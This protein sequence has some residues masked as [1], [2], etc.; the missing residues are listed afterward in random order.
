MNKAQHSENKPP[1]VSVL[2]LAYNH[3][4]YIEECLESIASQVCNFP[5]EV[6]VGEDCSPDDTR[7]KVVQIAARY[8]GLIRPILSESNLGAMMNSRNLTELARGKYIAF[9]EGDDYW[10]VN[11]KLQRQVDILE[12]DPE[13]TLVCA[14]ADA[15]FH[16]TGRRIRSIHERNGQ[17]DPPPED[18]TE[19]LLTRRINLFTCTACSPRE[20][21]LKAYRENPYEFS[22]NHPM[23]AI[24]LFL[25]L[26]R[27][28]KVVPIRESMATY[29]V[30]TESTSRS[31][32]LSKV[33][34]FQVAA[35]EICEHY[36]RKFGYGPDVFRKIWFSQFWTMFDLVMRS[37]NQTLREELNHLIEARAIHPERLSQ[38]LAFWILDKP[39]R[40]EQYQR[41]SSYFL[42]ARRAK[43]RL[44]SIA[45]RYA[46]EAKK[47]LARN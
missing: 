47:K 4:P 10:N 16:N 14:D 12:S 11:N 13:V 1:L 39:E 45:A 22:S 25:E 43:A 32:D 26:S 2:V 19:A 8:P 27:Q 31:K 46:R 23:G 44:R 28:G 29:R 30:I 20:L 3:G 36:A 5:F 17:W 24:Q 37:R 21:R 38:R 18:I 42:K 33:F 34:R 9:C 6:L 40:I 7:E 35:L 15:Y 41:F